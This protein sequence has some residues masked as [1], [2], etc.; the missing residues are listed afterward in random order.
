MR[1]TFRVGR[2][3]V[4]VAG[5]IAACGALAL[6]A[7]AQAAPKAPQAT[8]Q[9]STG[10][11][12]VWFALA[13][14]GAAGTIYYPVEFSNVSSRTCWLYGY[15]AVTGLNSRGR[16]IGPSAGH[17]IAP[18]RKVTLKPGQTAHAL[19]GIVEAGIIGGCRSATGSA[20]GV[21]PPSAKRQQVVSDFSFPA[22]TNKVY[23]RVY[24]VQA[25]IG[26]P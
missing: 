25:G 5:A 10:Q 24:P 1:L 21:I 19:L 26:V 13:P 11:T 9:C 17:Y 18:R 16:A 2:R 4:A 7:V 6:P 12:Y 22:C 20:L 14:S 23:M 15:P 3:A 8:P